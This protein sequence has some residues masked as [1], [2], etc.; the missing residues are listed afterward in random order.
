MTAP[1]PFRTLAVCALLLAGG[2]NAGALTWDAEPSIAQAFGGAAIDGPASGS[3]ADG[4]AA[5]ER[6]AQADCSAAAAQA[7]AQTG[8]Q[9]LSVSASS[10][11]GRTVCVVTVLIPGQGGERPRRTTITIPG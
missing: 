3:A 5:P 1:S 4:D 7:A 6:I 10:Q 11:G 8:G 2:Q 9:V